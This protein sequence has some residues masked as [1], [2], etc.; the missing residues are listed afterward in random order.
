MLDNASTLMVQAA[1]S[2]AGAA[3]GASSGLLHAVL[4]PRHL[5]EYSKPRTSLRNILLAGDDWHLCS[6]L[7]RFLA[8]VDPENE[9]Y[10]A[11]PAA[12]FYVCDVSTDTESA[13]C[14]LWY[15][16][17][18]RQSVE[19]LGPAF[20]ELVDAAIIVM[21]IEDASTEESLHETWSFWSSL[22]R[23]G[24]EVQHPMG[25]KGYSKPIVAYVRRGYDLSGNQAT[26]LQL[27]DGQ[28]YEH[29]ETVNEEERIKAAFKAAVKLS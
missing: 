18:G 22:L 5:N 23:R 2:V 20:F 7:A 8:G 15:L 6:R 19:V 21:S 9:V 24:G 1:Y 3:V 28:L 17:C 25:H 11:H 27:A 13:T 4:R 14:C 29:E 10:T 16:G 26:D 12:D